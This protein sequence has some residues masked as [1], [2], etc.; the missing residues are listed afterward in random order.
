MSDAGKL[1]RDLQALVGA[2]AAPARKLPERPAATPVASR[3][4]VAK[5]AAPAAS[6]AGIASPLTEESFADREW[7]PEA[8]IASS[9]GIFTFSLYRLKSVQMTDANGLPV[10]LIFAAP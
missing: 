1:Q 4:G 9:D 10:Q 7:H 8:I 3:T 2:G 5:P 6:G